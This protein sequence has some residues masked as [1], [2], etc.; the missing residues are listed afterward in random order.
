MACVYTVSILISL[1]VLDVRLFLNAALSFPHYFLFRDFQRKSS[2]I[3]VLRRG[4]SIINA[5]LNE[6][7][8]RSV[9]N[10]WTTSAPC[11]IICEINNR[12]FTIVVINAPAL[13]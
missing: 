5:N 11:T 10:I 9:S 13:L 7:M 3:T 6:N 4:I 12:V 1:L 8:Q 2:N